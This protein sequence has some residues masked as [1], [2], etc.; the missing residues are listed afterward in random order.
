MDEIPIVR[1]PAL[2]G[3]QAESWQA[4]I[5][6]APKLGQHWLLVGGQMVFLHEVERQSNDVR[7]T[8]D[9][10]VV[11]DLR[12]EPAALDRMHSV[13]MATKF[14][15]DLPSPEGVAHRYRR[16]G[17]TIDVLAP[18]HIGKRAR[19]SLGR[20]A[21]EAPGTTQALVRS[22]VVRVELSNGDAALIR[23]A[24]LVGALLGKVAAVAEIVSQS[25]A[26]RSKHLRDVDA[27]ARLMGPADR[28]ESVLSLKERLAVRRLADDPE[29]SK[30]AAASLLLL[31][32]PLT[33]P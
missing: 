17:A 3:R 31:V 26:E 6:V 24:T 23:V 8:D 33:K 19:L 9:I 22:S 1:L 21:I 27:L 11:L 4:L 13:L 30:L 20:R 14:V 28:D 32:G 12:V 18:D 29:L 25:P 15:Q 2:A 7:P 5:E 10:D 16:G